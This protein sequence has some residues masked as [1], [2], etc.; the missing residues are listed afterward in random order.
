MI[1]LN[2]SW[3]KFIFLFLTGLQRYL[4][5]T[6]ISSCYRSFWSEIQAL[7]PTWEI[8]CACITLHDQRGEYTSTV[9]SLRWPVSEGVF[10]SYD[11]H[12]VC[13]SNINKPTVGGRGAKAWGWTAECDYREIKKGM[14]VL[15][16]YCIAVLLAS[17]R[18]EGQRKG[19]HSS[20]SSLHSTQTRG[21]RHHSLA[22]W[23]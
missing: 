20:Q 17:T 7:D 3:E 12:I 6:T 11:V 4:S 9:G 19:Q 5:S 15:I 21:Y 18:W 14:W 10:C 13:Q 1:I 8:K 23:P 22:I 16:H 2:Y